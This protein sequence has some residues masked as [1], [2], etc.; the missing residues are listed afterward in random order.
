MIQRH[1]CRM[2]CIEGKIKIPNNANL[3]LLHKLKLK[4]HPQ[5]WMAFL[6]YRLNQPFRT[7]F[8]IG[9]VSVIESF[10]VGVLVS[11]I[12]RYTLQLNVHVNFE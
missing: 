2:M 7:A 4:S 6:N 5:K 8:W 3:Q 1:I 10:G 9:N 12:S 11:G